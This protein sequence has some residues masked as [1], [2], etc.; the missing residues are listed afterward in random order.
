MGQGQPIS[1]NTLSLV[2]MRRFAGLHHICSAAHFCYSAND[3]MIGN[4]FVQQA[5]G[6]DKP[7]VGIGT[8]AVS[9]AVQI[10]LALTDRRQDGEKY[11]H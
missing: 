9:P 3:L 11:W 5:V 4:E 6:R 7:L 10:V 2:G 8:G 1:V